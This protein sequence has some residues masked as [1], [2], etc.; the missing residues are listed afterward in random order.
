[1][2]AVSTVRST[3]RTAL[4]V[5][6]AS[7]PGVQFEGFTTTV[8]TVAAGGFMVAKNCLIALSRKRLKPTIPPHATT[9]SSR[10]P[11]MIRKRFTDSPLEPATGKTSMSGH[12]ST[13]GPDFKLRALY[14]TVWTVLSIPHKLM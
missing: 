4:T 9:S 13:M 5:P 12:V 3:P 14:C 2:P 11:V 1:M 8:D 10:I 7:T 6:I